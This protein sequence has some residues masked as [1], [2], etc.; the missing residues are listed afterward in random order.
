MAERQKG[1]ASLIPKDPSVVSLPSFI[2]VDGTNIDAQ[3]RPHPDQPEK[4]RGAHLRYPDRDAPH[5]APHRRAR[6]H[7]ALRD[8][9]VQDL[10]HRGHGSAARSISSSC[11]TPIR[12]SSPAGRRSWSTS[13]APCRELGDVA[14]DIAAQ[15]LP[16]C[17]DID[18]DQAARFGITP[19]TIDNALY[20]LY[21]QRIVSTIFTELEPVSRHPRGRSIRW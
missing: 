20:D 7:H 5:Q 19:A 21:G 10:T 1:L 15:G 11:R 12:T 6:R 9:M 3:L 16:A 2:G 13:C 17:V 4:P 18:R 8:S 14:T